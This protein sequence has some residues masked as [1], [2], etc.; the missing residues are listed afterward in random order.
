M[1]LT[2]KISGTW[3]EGAE[4]GGEIFAV[5]LSRMGYHV[6]AHRHSLPH[7]Q[8]GRTDYT[9]R[10]ADHP[11][12]HHAN[13]LDLLVAL[14]AAGVT[15]NLAELRPGGVVLCDPAHAPLAGS[16][17]DVT[18]W[19]VPLD[20]M[21]ADLG[22]P[23][24]ESAAALGASAAALGLSPS[25]FRGV[26][27]A[28]FAA[29]GERAAAANVEA[30][31][32]GYE[33]VSR[34][35]WRLVPGLPAL[36]ELPRRHLLVSGYDAFT[37][38]ALAAGCRFLA[39]NPITPTTEIQNRLS[40]YFE[41]FG[42]AVVAAED[43]LAAIHL[44]MGAAVA[45]LRALTAASGPGLS[46]MMGALGRAGAAE[47][48]VVIV[49]VQPGRFSW[50]QGDVPR[51]VIAPA[52]VEDCYTYGAE[53]FNLAERYRTP[54]VVAFDT[55]LGRCKA[56]ADPLSF[57]P[58]AVD[59]VARRTG[60]RS[61]F[62]SDVVRNRYI[63]PRCPDV[64][65][66]GWGSTYGPIQEARAALQAFG[67]KVGHLHVGLLSP[68]AT[69]EVS[70]RIASARRVVVVE[71]DADEGLACLLKRLCGAQDCI[72]SCLRYDGVPLLLEDLLR[73]LKEVA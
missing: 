42:G 57:E 30:F 39:V 2:W 38:G 1:D 41:R 68:F 54:V 43:E 31:Q 9:V 73:A 66:A 21:V 26:F 36:P 49:D 53:A 52:T 37:L 50:W 69:K 47:I 45:G 65:L 17:P 4:S 62:Q 27:R 35:S 64:L 3:G 29:H 24:L 14:D 71:Q 67:V 34:Q 23:T 8:G 6:F 63:G 5:T 51:I 16:R 60:D 56:T 10:V 25:S 28:H 46:L 59:R 55:H 12:R 48:P 22:T 61:G 13:R 72:M 58:V 19:P 70:S 18:C 15:H 44:A 11:V 33:H 20:S 32:R 7:V 40:K